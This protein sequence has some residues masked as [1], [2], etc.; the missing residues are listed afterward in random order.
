MIVSGR[1]EMSNEHSIINPLPDG[2]LDNITNIRTGLADGGH[3]GARRCNDNRGHLGFVRG[4]E[5]SE[6]GRT[7]GGQSR[8]VWHLFVWEWIGSLPCHRRVPDRQELAQVVDH[9]IGGLLPTDNH[10]DRAGCPTC[11]GCERHCASSS[12]ERRRPPRFG[13]SG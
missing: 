3:Q 10:D 4:N 1:G 11:H 5:S 8:I 13:D 2:E 12:G 7:L 6:D 9:R